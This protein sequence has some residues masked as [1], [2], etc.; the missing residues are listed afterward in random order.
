MLPLGVARKPL[1]SSTRLGHAE[2]LPLFNSRQTLTWMASENTTLQCTPVHILLGI[3]AQLIPEYDADF[4]QVLNGHRIPE[5]ADELLKFNTTLGEDGQALLR[6]S[7]GFEGATAN[8]VAYTF[9]C[10]TDEPIRL[11]VESRAQHAPEEPDTFSD[12]ALHGNRTAFP[13]GGF[14]AWFKGRGAEDILHNELVLALI[15]FLPEVHML[16]GVAIAGCSFEPF[17][18]STRQESSAM[19]VSI[20]RPVRPI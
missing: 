3:P 17:S 19:I 12:G 2:L 13:S 11:A 9:T 6:R 7:A 8:T 5:G 1:A 4:Y 10:S 15:A 14:G 16:A 18:S 20:P